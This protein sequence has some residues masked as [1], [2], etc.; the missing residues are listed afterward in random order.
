MR[1]SAIEFRLRVAII[2]AVI[3]LGFWAP[4]TELFVL[5]RRSSL[6]EWGA[7]ELVRLGVCNFAA[8]TVG[9]IALASLLAFKGAWLRVWGAAYLGSEVVYN[10]EMK[11]DTMRTEGPYRFVR[12]P[13]YLGSWCMVAAICFL[14]PPTGALWTMALLTLFQLRLIAGEEAFLTRKLG[15]PYL[16]YLEA[17]PRLMP[18]LIPRRENSLIRTGCK[19]RWV[20]ALLAETNAIGVLLIF[21]VLAWR[22]DHTLMIKAVVVNF[23]LSLV[24]RAFLT[25]A[26]ESID[27]TPT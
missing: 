7:L 17:I 14:M 12:N 11:A 22:Y 24:V 9:M 1:A 5:S 8:A 15:A 25:P 21:V 18:Q 16:S 10:A 20:H 23:G 6:L 4:W 27:S 2:A 13:L 19:P 26:M 3:G